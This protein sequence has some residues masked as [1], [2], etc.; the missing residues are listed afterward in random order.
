MLPP[1]TGDY[2]EAQ[3][4][5]CE[6]ANRACVNPIS[7]RSNRATTRRGARNS[8]PFQEDRRPEG[9]RAIGSANARPSLEMRR[10]SMAGRGAHVLRGTRYA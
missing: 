7:R 2:G 8:G 4:A 6:P 10:V 1:F 5:D 3:E 9:L